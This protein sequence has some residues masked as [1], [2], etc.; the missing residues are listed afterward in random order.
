LVLPATDEKVTRAGA[1]LPKFRAVTPN[2]L[3]LLDVLMADRL[4]FTSA[5]VEAVTEKL[6]RPI[7]PKKT[8]SRVSSGR[9]ERP[10]AAAEGGA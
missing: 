5:A 1:N 9:G 7:R 10:I 4:V 2:T 8:A 3:N 6:L